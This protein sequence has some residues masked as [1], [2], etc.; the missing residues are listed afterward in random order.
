MSS[1]NATTDILVVGAGL[2]GLSA[3][4]ALRSSGRE[5]LVLEKSRGLGG[6][7]A[8]RRWH[9]WPV[10]HGAQFFTARTPDFRRQVDRW[11]A[12]GVSHEWTRG[13][14]QW[15]SA[16]LKAPPD[17]AHPRYACRDGM[18]TLGRSLAEASAGYIHTETRA[19]AAE[20]AGACWRVQTL[21]GPIYEAEGLVVAIPPPQ[22]SELLASEATVPE[23]FCGGL[24]LAPCLAV[25]ARYPRM[26]L[27][28]QGV[29]A[30]GHPV[31]SWIG[32]DTSKRPAAHPGA[33]VLVLHGSAEFS[34]QHAAAPE[35]SFVP[36]MLVAAAAMT[37]LALEAPEDFF[38]QRWRYA[39]ATSHSEDR[40]LIRRLEGPAPLVLAGD[41]VAGGK[42]EGAWSSGLAAA[43]ALGATTR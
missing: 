17:E 25:V 27:P 6:R 10:D 38:L 1:Q 28:W 40:P 34:R 33:T 26:S 32:H 9:G 7:A 13:F 5:V 43:R 3:A 36:D 18:A 16:G 30:P 20:R 14:H 4:R 42:I 12:A 22:A 19:V 29:Q 21:N 15:T 39:L 31:I 37:G 41:A 11:L 23:D 8:T 2:A 35:G 24:A